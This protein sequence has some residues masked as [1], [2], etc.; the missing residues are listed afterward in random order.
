MAKRHKFSTEERRFITQRAQSCCE[1]CKVFEDY[2][3]DIFT[4]DHI[5]AL[6]LGGLDDFSNL[7]LACHGCNKHK[8]DKI[9]ALD[10][11]SNQVV[12][13]FHPRLDI[14]EDHFQWTNR[15]LNIEG[16]SM[17]GRAT[18]ELLELNRQGLLNLRSALLLVGVHPPT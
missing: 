1:Y 4:I 16:I 18:V 6:S 5:I 3:P 13:L 10:P 12:S 7:A 9:Q 8:R 17:T 14:W 15:F 11:V 2:S